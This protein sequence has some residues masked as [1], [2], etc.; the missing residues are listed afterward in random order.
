MS[1]PKATSSVPLRF[2]LV[3]ALVSLAQSEVSYSK[4]GGGYKASV[5]VCV[6]VFVQCVCVC[7]CVCMHAYVRERES[8]RVC[9]CVCMCNL[10]SA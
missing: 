5:C 9:V 7:V 6:C 2:G 1:P 10:S 8:V 4:Y 3:D